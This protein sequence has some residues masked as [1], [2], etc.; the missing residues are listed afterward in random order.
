MARTGGRSLWFAVPIGALCLAVVIGL[1]WFA[2]PL[3]PGVVGFVGDA[4]RFGSEQ[5]VD[6]EPTTPPAQSVTAEEDV[7]IDCRALYPNDLWGEV[8]WSPDAL[9]SQSADAP[10]T[11]VEGLTDVL[12]PDVAVTCAWRSEGGTLTT[13][14]SG[15][16]EDAV[17]VADAAL[18]GQGFACE[19]DESSLTCVRTSGDQVETHTIRDGVWLVSVETSWHPEDYAARVAAQVWG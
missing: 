18:R 13:S 1:G 9:L 16:G 6:P 17:T 11:A 15:V 19:T 14:L 4:L 12:S 7:D 5:N 3:V 10:A 8:L 2:A